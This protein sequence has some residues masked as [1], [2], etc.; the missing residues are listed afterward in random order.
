M[1]ERMIIMKGFCIEE[2]LT[3]QCYG[4]QH[5]FYSLRSFG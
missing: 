4:V 3:A 2:K 5:Q 1:G